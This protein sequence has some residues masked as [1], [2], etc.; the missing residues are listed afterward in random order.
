MAARRGIISTPPRLRTSR[1][2]V[3]D[4]M[5]RALGSDYATVHRGVYS[6]SAQMTLGYE[7]A[8]RRVADFIGADSENEVVFVR[9]ATEGINL[10]ASSWGG[11]NLTARRPH[12]VEPAGTSFQHRAVAVDRTENRGGDRCLS[13]DR[14]RPDRSRRPGNDVDARAQDRRAGA[15][16]QRAGV[17]SGRQTCGQAGPCSGCEAAARRLPGRAA[18]AVEHGGTG[19][20]FLRPVG[21][22]ALRSDRHRRAVGAGGTA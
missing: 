8:R 9:G 22:Q 12:R 4:A 15:C 3:I 5:A 11:A 7:A 18:H 14:R 13:V 6:R 2:S 19:V 21:P 1:K 20:R 16:L 10:V 17:D